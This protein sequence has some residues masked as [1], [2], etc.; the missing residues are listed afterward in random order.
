MKRQELP[1][2]IAEHFETPMTL[3][4]AERR[5]A[6]V[7]TDEEVEEMRELVRWFCTRYPT[8][9]ERFAY[10]RRKYEEWTRNPPA[11][12]ADLEQ[13][14]AERQGYSSGS[15]SPKSTPT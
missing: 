2:A 14:D 10:V 1:P 8:A 12:I 9:Q 13:P 4:D 15:S 11:S 5:L 7:P 6:V 3:E